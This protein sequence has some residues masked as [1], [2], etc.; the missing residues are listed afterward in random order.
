[1]TTQ[2]PELVTSRLLLR[3]VQFTDS[4]RIMEL[5]GD[6]RVYETTLNIPHPYDDGEAEKWI[7]SS[8]LRFY[9]G[10]GAELAITIRESGE[11]IGVIGLGPEAGHERAEL[12]YWIGVP[13]WNHGYCTE[14]ALAVIRFG[15]DVLGYHKITSR[16]MARNPAS[17][18]VMEKAGM[19]FEGELIDEV[20]KDGKFHT[21]KVYGILRG[22]AVVLTD[23][24]TSD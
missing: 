9:S 5:A 3:L 4:Y 15:F 12:G 1:M 10:K 8:L 20:L 6:R 23:G 18:R 14:A 13:Y 22:G 7:A 19:S 21:L 11:L 17:G 24:P 2:A 16:H